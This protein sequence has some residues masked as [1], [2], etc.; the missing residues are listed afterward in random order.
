MM[1][2]NFLPP[3]FR[4]HPTDVELVKYYLKRKVL[5]KKIAFKAIAE[6]D[7]YKYAPWDL[8]DMSC[9]K[10]GDL[11]WFFFCPVEKK[12]AKGSRLNR[13]AVHGYWKT[14]GKDRHVKE[15]NGDEVGMIKTLVFHR[16]KAPRGERT[17]WVMHEYRLTYMVQDTYVLCVI[18]KKGGVGARNGAQYGAPFKEDDWSDEEDVTGSLFRMPMLAIGGGNSSCVPTNQCSEQSVTSNACT[19][20]AYVPVVACVD[21][22]QIPVG[23]DI[24]KAVLAPQLAQVSSND[25]ISSMLDIFS[26]D[27]AFIT[28]DGGQMIGDATGNSNNSVL[29]APQYSDDD[30]VLFILESF[31]ED[32]YLNYV[33]YP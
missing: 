31:M 4:F 25:N 5:G 16:G 1:G 18:F 8:P 22:S 15:D 26:E 13:A 12:Y 6:V 14:T 21:G 28:Y 27:D 29:E 23:V 19:T 7:I 24:A 10:T 2:K 20:A 3:G 33:L 30:E 11:K 32:N 17:D 9:L